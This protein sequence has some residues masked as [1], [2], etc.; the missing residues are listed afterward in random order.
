M[1]SLSVT[2]PTGTIGG[3][4]S[5]TGPVAVPSTGGAITPPP[6]SAPHVSVNAPQATTSPVP[7]ASDTI[8]RNQAADISRTA[9][10]AQS[11]ITQQAA[12][13]AA[14]TP[15]PP[16]PQTTPPTDQ[17]KDS[18]ANFHN[19]YGYNSDG[20]RISNPNDTS[21]AAESILNTPE[22]GYRFAYQ[23]DGTQLEVPIGSPLPPGI[24][25]SKPSNPLTSGRP[26]QLSVTTDAGTGIVQFNDGTYAKVGAD[27]KYIGAATAQD[28][29]TAQTQSSQYQRDKTSNSMVDL[30]GKMVQIVNG[31]YP[32]TPNQQAQIDAVKQDFANLITE[33]RTANANYQGGVAVSQ[34][35]L[36]MSQYSPTLAIGTMKQAV[37]EG[38]AKISDLNAKLVS[39]VSKMIN[40]DNSDNMQML[41]DTYDEFQ[42]FATDKQTEFDKIRSASAAASKEMSDRAFE[43]QKE[44]DKVAKDNQDYEVAKMKDATSAAHYKASEE[45]S[46]YMAKIAAGRLGQETRKTDAYVNSV[47]QK[48]LTQK[49]LSDSSSVT[50]GLSAQNPDGSINQANLELIKAK[51]PPGLRDT[52]VKVGTY[53]MDLNSVKSAGDRTIVSNLVSGYFPAWKQQDFKAINDYNNNFK[54]KLSPTSLGGQLATL[55][56]IPLHLT[57][58]A[59]PLL[60]IN[61]SSFATVNKAD[62]LWAGL[63][64]SGSATRRTEL[65]QTKALS[66]FISGEEMKLIKG[67]APGEAE[68]KELQ[69][70]LAP[71]ASKESTV[72]T[73]KGF[74][75]GTD[76][77]L[78]G[79]IKQQEA[80]FGGHLSTDHPLMS[81]D[82]AAKMYDLAKRVGSD[83]TN[84]EKVLRNTPDGSVTLLQKTPAG[85]Q[86]YD[87]AQAWALSSPKIGRHLDN[88]EVMQRINSLAGINPSAMPIKMPSDTSVDTPPSSDAMD[89]IDNNNPESNQ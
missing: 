71:G 89:S 28:M 37:D 8:A 56:Q 65:G 66:Q 2:V 14:T 10:N 49:L 76:A 47:N 23:K 80:T 78:D 12:N 33:Q 6:V 19:T 9:Q 11:A 5:A 13:K 52:I 75:D 1:P 59:T 25:D 15:P 41:K 61:S 38:I 54:S 16:P 87:A 67:S 17:Q 74:V 79:L 4:D 43:Q 18:A 50:G 27:G 45:I 63:G 70:T 68:M 55:D 30:Q 31:T 3:A 35:L 20:K 84:V 88:T 60:D 77:K 21:S 58:L 44:K 40:A 82:S 53:G 48:L 85:Q 22:T 34:G 7:V 46:T 29:A 64:F 86:S 42:K 36:G 81:V 26:V 51:L 57:S 39:T 69:S 73:I 32:L 83:T 72:G 62:N 24:S